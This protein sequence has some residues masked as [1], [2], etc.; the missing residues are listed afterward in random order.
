MAL[1]ETVGMR[2]KPHN[3]T[4]LE[5]KVNQLIV[6]YGFH[7]SMSQIVDACL[8][9][10]RRNLSYETEILQEVI[11]DKTTKVVKCRKRWGKGYPYYRGANRGKSK[12]KV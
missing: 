1:K 11:S 8:D 4:Y 9:V 2:L 5:S 7:F 6:A 12:R 10:M 3:R